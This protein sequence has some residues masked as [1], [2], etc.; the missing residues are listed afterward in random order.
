MIFQTNTIGF[1]LALSVV[2]LWLA[3]TG[4]QSVGRYNAAQDAIA[5]YRDDPERYEKCDYSKYDPTADENAQWRNPTI[6]EVGDCRESIDDAEK[7]VNDR[8][9]WWNKRILERQAFSSFFRE[10]ILPAGLLLLIAGLW[11]RIAAV[12]RSYLGWLKSGRVAPEE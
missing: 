8:T 1:R 2:A 10:G 5:A 9:S 7:Y 3:Y 4:Y 12:G 11:R 6:K